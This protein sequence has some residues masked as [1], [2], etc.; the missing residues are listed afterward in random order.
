M[1][2]CVSVCVCVCFDGKAQPKVA[3]EKPGVEPANPDL[4][5]INL[6]SVSNSK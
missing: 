5:A 2:E 4:E 6:S 3:L 1:C